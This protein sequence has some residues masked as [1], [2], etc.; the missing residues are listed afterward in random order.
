MLRLRRPQV[1]TI[2]SLEE[3]QSEAEMH[4]C[5]LLTLDCTHFDHLFPAKGL[6]SL[7]HND[8]GTSDPT[9]LVAVMNMLALFAIRRG[10][11]RVI[12]P[13]YEETDY[14]ERVCHNLNV[15]LDPPRAIGESAKSPFEF[16]VQQIQ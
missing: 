7:L 9:K 4:R 6:Y 16:V 1:D 15:V 5:K 3:A 10:Y 12:I 11:S 2:K 13:G 8:D 14:L